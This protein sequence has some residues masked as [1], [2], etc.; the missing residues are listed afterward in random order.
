MIQLLAAVAELP[1][2]RANLLATVSKKCSNLCFSHSFPLLSTKH[3]KLALIVVH[4]KLHKIAK[5]QLKN[6]VSCKVILCF[7]LFK[8]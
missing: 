3:T 7:V 4:G 2:S 6:F 8:K 1:G 5:F